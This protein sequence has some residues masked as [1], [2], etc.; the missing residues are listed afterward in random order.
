MLIKYAGHLRR[1][2]ETKNCG[3][4]DGRENLEILGIENNKFVKVR[5]VSEHF[6]VPDLAA[7]E[8]VFKIQKMA[9]TKGE[10]VDLLL[11]L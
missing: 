10:C 9:A 1:S 3:V 5:V 2:L 7:V 11:L 6:S 8:S 4:W